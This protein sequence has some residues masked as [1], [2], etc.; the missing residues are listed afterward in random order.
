MRYCIFSN[1][2]GEVMQ[3][4]TNATAIGISNEM[5]VNQLELSGRMSSL[6]S[7][8]R[9]QSASDDTA[10][11]Q[12]SN[13]LGKLT[14][15]MN[16]AIRNA[17]DGISITQTAE[18]AA[19]EVT[20]VLHRMR[21]L[22]IQSA[23]AT[24]TAGDRRAIQQEVDQLKNELNRIAE[25]TTFGGQN[26]LDGTF[27]SQQFQVGAESNETIGVA[28][29]SVSTEGLSH[30]ETQLEGRATRA[31]YSDSSLT[32]A[33]AQI[34]ANGFGSGA[35]GPATDTLT[36]V[37]TNTQQVELS[38]SDSASQMAKDINLAFEQTGVTAH[39]TTSLALHVHDGV[40]TDRVGFEAGENVSFELG[41]GSRSETVWFTASGDYSDDLATLANRI[42]E[43][44][45]STGISAEL[46]GTNQQLILTSHAGDNIE[47][48]DYTEG[49][50]GVDNQLAIRAVDYD[51]SFGAATTLA[52]DGS[53]A[54]V[55]G[56]VTLSSN[57]GFS[58]SG[59]A[60]FGAANN[61]LGAG[62]TDI[63]SKEASVAEIDMTTAEGSQRAISIL[64]SAIS[65]VD[66]LRSML[67][68]VQNRFSSTIANLAVTHENTSAANSRILDADVSKETAELAK[69]QVTQQATTA[70]MSQANSMKDQAIR[71]LG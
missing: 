1:W 26:L 60:D 47:I 42:N 10:N 55:R 54:I 49:S 43:N 8:K 9:I 70:L 50:E 15:G 35:P 7:G 14:N 36:I 57:E 20:N 45:A 52:N 3:I 69:L 56:T 66:G 23:N 44:S 32:A 11:M 31:T 16:V 46:D 5:R 18:G 17:N 12:I 4:A 39:A 25:T 62:N 40:D 65:Q 41:N 53:A 24:N 51:D 34:E 38:S 29:V 61:A 71:L 68:G 59:D 27:G 64:D 22:A 2:N 33:R 28:L 30:N 48:S 13:R 21:D 19:Q 63:N 6:G 67:G 37:G 58:L